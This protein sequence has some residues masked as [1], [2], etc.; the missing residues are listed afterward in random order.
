MSGLPTTSFSVDGRDYA[1]T[2]L[3]AREA[4]VL[5]PK[6]GALIG[7]DLVSLMLATKD[8]DSASLLE[9]PETLGAIISTVAENAAKGNGLLL[10]H[11]LMRHTTCKQIQLANSVV[12]ASVYDAFD[13]HFAGEYMHLINVA[14][15]VARASFIKP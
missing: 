14:I 15:Q 13:T 7:R 1:T 8:L 12:E 11:E 6:L 2:L 3:P 9:D 4:L 10:L 5:L